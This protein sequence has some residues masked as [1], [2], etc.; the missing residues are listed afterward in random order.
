MLYARMNREYVNEDELAKSRVREFYRKQNEAMYGEEKETKMSPGALSSQL[1]YGI[2][3]LFENFRN[4]VEQV[5][6]A[7]YNGDLTQQKTYE[8]IKK[9]NQLSSYLKNVI[10]IKALTKDDQDKIE[11]EFEGM[12]DKLLLLKKIATDNNFIDADDISD[13]VDTILKIKVMK[14]LEKV[15]SQSVGMVENIKSKNESLQLIQDAINNLLTIDT[16]LRNPALTASTKL[17]KQTDLY[18]ALN[19]IFNNPDLNPLEFAQIR[20]DA[21]E[22]AKLLNDIKSDITFFENIRRK[23]QSEGK[24][25][26]DVL[27]NGFDSLTDT[28]IK[29]KIDK[30]VDELKIIIANSEKAQLDKID[31]ADPDILLKTTAIESKW[32]AEL[33][34]LDPKQI[35]KL[36]N[37][38]ITNRDTKYK[39]EFPTF[40]TDYK[41][42]S[43]YMNANNTLDENALL[44]EEEKINKI[45]LGLNKLEADLIKN[46]DDNIKAFIRPIAS[47]KPTIGTKI[48]QQKPTKTK[49]AAKTAPKPTPPPIYTTY[50]SF[51]NKYEKTVDD[52]IKN[53]S[54]YKV[55]NGQSKHHMTIKSR[56][57]TYQGL[58]NTDKELFFT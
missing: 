29:S 25:I 50:E 3:S 28:N 38:E 11:K 5:L 54:K 41:N 14:G 23:L 2:D 39:N 10:D 6:A 37:K 20:T 57:K 24:Y 52:Y 1:K 46:L 42:T 18:N 9:Y 26:E 21:T 7:D 17:K 22:V 27:S 13:M 30:V 31:P 48:V 12:R 53:Q 8:V 34:K 51:K 19:I 49:A 55:F 36:I 33:I 45:R 47:A 44:A 56:W 16:D 32:K 58:T 43:T 15:S 40:G 35:N 4:A